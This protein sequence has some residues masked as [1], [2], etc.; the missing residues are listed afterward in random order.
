MACILVFMTAMLEEALSLR[1]DAIHTFLGVDLLSR[2]KCRKY[3]E[4]DPIS[5]R[6][7]G[8]TPTAG[9]GVALDADRDSK[10]LQTEN[11]IFDTDL[12]LIT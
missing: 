2:G 3:T 7:R 9:I 10:V 12:N 8:G 11:I 6:L 5:T 4:G 1:L